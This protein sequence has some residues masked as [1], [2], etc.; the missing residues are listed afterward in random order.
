MGYK[1]CTRPARASAARQAHFQVPT[2]FQTSTS[3]SARYMIIPI[4]GDPHAATTS[5]HLLPRKGGGGRGGSSGRSSGKP[6]SSSSSDGSSGKLGSISVSSGR[7]RSSASSSS[8]GGGTSTVLPSGSPFAG[9]LSGGATRVSVFSPSYILWRI[10]ECGRVPGR[11]VR[12]LED[13]EWLPLWRLWDLLRRT[14][15]PVRLLP[16]IRGAKLLWRR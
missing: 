5:C 1:K 13:R 3:S 12:K 14:P 8:R 15:V 10:V 9:R 11:G 4:P 2:P 7:T 16:R 6:S